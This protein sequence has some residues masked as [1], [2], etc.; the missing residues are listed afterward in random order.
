MNLITMM[1]I[2][3]ASKSTKA[4][5]LKEKYNAVLLSSDTLREKLNLYY[6]DESVF[7]YMSD[8]AKKSISENKSVIIDSTNLTAKT[9]ARCKYL[10]NKDIDCNF[11]CYYTVTHPYKWIY[12]AK[13]RIEDRWKN[14]E[15]M[16]SM[17][18]I[19]NKH[20]DSLKFP[21]PNIFDDIILDVTDIELKQKHIRKFKKYY[22][23]NIDLFLKNPRKFF[24]NIYRD[25]L[26]KKVIPELYLC[27]NFNQKNHHHSLTL[28]NHIFTVAENLKEVTIENIWIAIL[29]DIGKALYKLRKEK[30]N[31]EYSYHGH[32][33]AS[34][35]MA[36]CILKRLGFKDDF[37]KRVALIISYHMYI[38]YEEKL[39]R[40]KKKYIGKELYNKLLDFRDADLKAK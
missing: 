6:K 36:I 29:H 16:N 21:L 18:Y 34:T 4:Q 33:G 17:F 35:E 39:D 1:G 38:P 7:V 28:E 23:S 40:K 20:F 8:L 15:T 24:D 5:L 12:N 2:S 31:G 10:I 9:H 37:I 11:I 25:G 19:R 22:N 14:Y 13:A 3:C 32:A 27:Y 30:Y 26:L